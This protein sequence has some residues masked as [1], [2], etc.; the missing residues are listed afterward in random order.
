MTKSKSVL[1]LVF[2]KSKTKKVESDDRF[3]GYRVVKSVLL[4]TT[5]LYPDSFVKP[6][7]NF[8]CDVK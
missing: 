2:K 8:S 5:K 6:I 4:Q 1:P 7:S 3:H